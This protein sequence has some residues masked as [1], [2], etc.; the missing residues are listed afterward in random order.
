[1]Q[2]C[3]ECGKELV[4]K[5]KGANSFLA[6]SGYPDCQ[7]T[8]GLREQADI[9]PENLGVAC[10][11]CGE[12]LQLKSGRYGLF[13][14]CSAFPACDFVAEPDATNDSEGHVDCP[15]CLRDGRKGQLIQKTSRSGRSFYA[16]NQY[17][18]CH[19]SVN[20]TP[21]AGVCPSCEFPLLLQKKTRGVIRNICARKSCDYKSEPL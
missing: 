14:G 13:V 8:Q 6:C 16:C 11:Q 15:E 4:V 2:R 10:P 3:P 19:Y 21:V 9:E 7:F 20:L 18:Q 5:H 1:M 12:E 17:P